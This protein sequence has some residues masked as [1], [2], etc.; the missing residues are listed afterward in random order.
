MSTIFG[1]Q[2]SF[3]K[4]GFLRNTLLLLLVPCSLLHAQP[5]GKEKT[6]FEFIGPPGAMVYTDLKTALKEAPLVYKMDL[7]GQLIEPKTVPKIAKL[8]NV[9]ALKIGSNNFSRL[10]EPFTKMTAL[11]FLSSK[12]NA[13][14]SLP[15]NFVFLQELRYLE[16]VGTAFD[17]FP[18]PLT[19]L[20]RLKSLQIQSN[21]ADTLHM[22]KEIKHIGGTLEQLL[23]YNTRIDSLPHE[24]GE[25][26]KVKSF[27]AVGCSLT[28]LPTEIG[29][30]KALETLVLDNNQLTALPR[31][32]SKLKNLG[33]LSLQN[34]KLT[35]L[36]DQICFLTNLAVLDLRGNS[37]SDYDAAVLKVLLPGC[38]IYR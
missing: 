28:K 27:Y 21:K 23:F 25:L 31:E 20:G 29:N 10:P 4:N 11:Q 34:N 35:N 18:A 19:Y 6:P 15:K 38:T 2:T 33:Y 5:G 24:I 30:M 1:N 8:T 37:I 22:I 36:P 7:T 16:F 3:F 26:K 12:D 17:T 9:Q 13:L 14:D 32:I